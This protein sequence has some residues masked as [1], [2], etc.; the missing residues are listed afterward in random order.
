MFVYQRVSIRNDCSMGYHGIL[1]NITRYHG[2][3]WD[4][5]GYYWI[6]TITMVVIYQISLEIH[7]INY[8]LQGG[9]P[10]FDS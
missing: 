1:L 7:D 6:L 5:A 3:S 2:I 8:I 9:N 10:L 4:I